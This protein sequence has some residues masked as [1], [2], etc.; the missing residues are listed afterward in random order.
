M[1]FVL[2]FGPDEIWA[3]YGVAF[4]IVAYL[5]YPLA[6]RRPQSGAYDVGQTAQHLR[7]DAADVVWNDQKARSELRPDEGR[8][9]PKRSQVERRFS[10]AFAFTT[11][12]AQEAMI[13]RLMLKHGVDRLA[14][15][16]IALDD[17]Y[18]DRR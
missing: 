16:K 2:E 1:T 14:A 8:N 3:A 12:A 18:R 9:A 11:P 5:V 17:L 10:T 7:D 15:M 4:F 13:S 6:I